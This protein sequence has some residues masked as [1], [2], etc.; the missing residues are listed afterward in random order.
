MEIEKDDKNGLTIISFI[1]SSD[2]ARF[3]IKIGQNH[4]TITNIEKIA[5]NK[6]KNLFFIYFYTSNN[7]KVLK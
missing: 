7:I 1:N 3:I 2:E 6:V 4:K 5:F